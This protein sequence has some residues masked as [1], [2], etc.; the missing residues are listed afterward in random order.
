MQSFVE[1]MSHAMSNTEE[2]L[3]G[4]RKPKTVTEN[5]PRAPTLTQNQKVSP[6]K[7]INS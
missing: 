1:G 2:K 7:R 4:V 3:R 5:K 6:E